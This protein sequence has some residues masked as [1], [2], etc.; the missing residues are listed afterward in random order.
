MASRRALFAISTRYFISHPVLY[1]LSI[2]LLCLER[3]LMICI[4]ALLSK[5]TIQ[6]SGRNPLFAISSFCS[7]VGFFGCFNYCCPLHNF[8]FPVYWNTI[9]FSDCQSRFRRF[10]RQPYLSNTLNLFSCIFY[11]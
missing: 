10:L 5:I 1:P 2:V 9:K 11:Q 7:L 4:S 3:R 6:F 8:D